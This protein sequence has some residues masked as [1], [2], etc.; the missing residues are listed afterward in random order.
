ML[1]QTGTFPGLDLR[2]DSVKWEMHFPAEPQF[3]PCSVQW[4]AGAWLVGGAHTA[5][6][7]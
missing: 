4:R 1:M 5:A 3:P 7:T 2:L 6:Q